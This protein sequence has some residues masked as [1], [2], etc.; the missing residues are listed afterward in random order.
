VAT[1]QARGWEQ[2]IQKKTK[3]KGEYIGDTKSDEGRERRD[4]GNYKNHGDKGSWGKFDGDIGD[5]E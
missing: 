3:M 1:K 4:R 2:E 5:G